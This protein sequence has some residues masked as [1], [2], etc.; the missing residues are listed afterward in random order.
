M[1]P[2]ADNAAEWL[3]RLFHHPEEVPLA[4][5]V[6]LDEWLIQRYRGAD[7]EFQTRI[8]SAVSEIL[9]RA[10]ADAAG[11]DPEELA[12][13]LH[14]VAAARV[15]AAIPRLRTLLSMRVLTSVKG[16]YSDLHGRALE[17]LAIL[18]GLEPEETWNVESQFRDH[19]AI[20]FSIVRDTAPHLIAGILPDVA[21]LGFLAAAVRTVASE[22]RTEEALRI[23][24]EAAERILETN[25]EPMFQEFVDALVGS[26]LSAHDRLL[27]TRPLLQMDPHI[28]KVVVALSNPLRATVGALLGEAGLSAML[29]PEDS[30]EDTLRNAAQH[31]DLVVY[32]PQVPNEAAILR[33][34][35][36]VGTYRL[37]LAFEGDPTIVP[38]RGSAKSY[39]LSI[40]RSTSARDV[41][42]SIR[43]RVIQLVVF[44]SAR[45]IVHRRRGP[46]ARF[47]TPSGTAIDMQLATLRAVAHG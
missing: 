18:G 34:S 3:I 16:I 31:G 27:I 40:P 11:Q 6:L 35:E 47:P 26:C 17:A 33:I 32:G 36:T 39:L 7:R 5:G 23:L 9:D 21:R 29:I 46:M 2:S 28:R 8:D 42:L 4:P 19:A 25:E 43:D 44:S 30:P 14:V 38:L 24:K 45:T 12:W 37:R 15:A 1:S 41:G 20:A 10:I 13:T 22:L